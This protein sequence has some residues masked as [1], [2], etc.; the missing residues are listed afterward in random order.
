[1]ETD[2]KNTGGFDDFSK[3]G[4][5][6]PYDVPADFFNEFPAKTLEL[7]KVQNRKPRI[8]TIW[9][10]GVAAS[11]LVLVALGFWVSMNSEKVMVTEV[12]RSEVSVPSGQVQENKPVAFP[13]ETTKP[14]QKTEMPK[15]EIKE[16]LNDILADL[17]DE[18]LNQL[19]AMIKTD[20]FMEV[21]LPNYLNE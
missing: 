14:V 11:V 1:M 15:P 12:K 8:A 2:S 19:D 20:M 3:F 5:R 18:D 4:K 7:A 6:L 17:S 21:A 13:N 16:T 10:W 9:Y